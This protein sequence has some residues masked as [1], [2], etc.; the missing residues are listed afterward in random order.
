M[1]D[2]VYV[3]ARICILSLT[4]LFM[5]LF[6]FDVY[7][8]ILDILPS[9]PSLLLADNPAVV[10]IKD[11]TLIFQPSSTIPTTNALTE[12]RLTST[13][14]VIDAINSKIS[15][16][17][18]IQSSPLTT[19]LAPTTSNVC[20]EGTINELKKCIY[21]YI[22]EYNY[23][24]HQIDPARLACRYNN[25]TTTTSDL[26]LYTVLLSQAAVVCDIDVMLH[27][28][29]DILSYY[30]GLG[31]VPDSISDMGKIL[32]DI[33][34]FYSEGYA[35]YTRQKAIKNPISP[36][37]SIY[38]KGHNSDPS[39]MLPKGHNSESYPGVLRLSHDLYAKI[40]DQYMLMNEAAAANYARREGS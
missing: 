11:E 28:Y 1:L 30:T 40:G 22:S 10:N 36:T 15:S 18:A 3:C 35:Y 5:L 16:H 7:L 27:M 2:G 9:L 12:P 29:S 25:N 38:E 32:T 20:T 19:L 14:T 37:G 13:T 31:E 4:I 24:T 39:A 8:S 6:M 21:E 23:Y 17:I 34:S 33:I 26:W